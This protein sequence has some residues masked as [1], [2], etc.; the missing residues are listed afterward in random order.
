MA[1]QFSL[2]P[3][4]LMYPRTVMDDLLLLFRDGLTFTRHSLTK[5][6]KDGSIL[7]YHESSRPRTCPHCLSHADI[8]HR[9]GY[10]KRFLMTIRSCHPV[11]LEI[12][13][14]RWLCTRCMLTVSFLPPDI[15]PYKRYCTLTIFLML[16]LYVNHLSGYHGRFQPQTSLLMQWSPRT[17]ARYVRIAK[18][19][20][21]V[22]HQFVREVILDIGEPRP[23]EAVFR[24]GLS[25]PESLLSRNRNDRT[26]I[27]ILWQTGA[28]LLVARKTFSITLSILLARAHTKALSLQQRFII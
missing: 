5:R 15:I 12:R 21:L 24:S 9:H 13:N 8:F 17:L 23:L 6:V 20:A 4:F 10:Y 27:S 14:L 11:R 28:M 18:H 3:L 16:W 26:R 7:Y 22:T 25:P 19:R 2:P 1:D